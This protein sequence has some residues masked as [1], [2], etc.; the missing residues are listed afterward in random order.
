M[1]EIKLDKVRNLRIDTA[2][3]EAAEKALGGMDIFQIGR[4]LAS[5][6]VVHTVLWAGLLHE[7]PKLAYK[8]LDTF[9]ET[10]FI[11]LQNAVD[12]E[13]GA[14]SAKQEGRPSPLPDSPGAASEPSHGSASG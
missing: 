11:E 7:D 9:F 14:W 4:S 5:V 1:R 3:I 6:R 12:A 2:A 13:L 8:D 10:R